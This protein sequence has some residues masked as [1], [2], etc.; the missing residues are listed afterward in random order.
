MP[1]TPFFSLDLNT[2]SDNKNLEYQIQCIY[3]N[4]SVSKTEQLTYYFDLSGQIN[5][6]DSYLETINRKVTSLCNKHQF[7]GEI[8]NLIEAIILESIRLDKFNLSISEGGD[9][10]IVISTENNGEFSN[11]AVDEDGDVSY[12]FFA[13]N[14]EN[15]K[16]K[17]YYYENKLDVKELA[18]L[19]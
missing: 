5:D 6:D 15:S 10:Q 18:S 16:R 2:A 12:M 4:D 8:Q 11:L 17:L 9:E 1:F 14:K 3:L 7:S 13:R 19:L